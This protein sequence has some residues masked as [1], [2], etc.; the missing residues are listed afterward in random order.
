MSNSIKYDLERAIVAAITVISCGMTAASGSDWP[1]FRGNMQRTGFCTRS[2]VAPP[3]SKWLWQTALPGPIYSSPAVHDSLLFIGARDSNVYAL[4]AN[5]GAVVWRFKTGGQVESSPLFSNNTIY[6]GSDDGY[7]YGLDASGGRKLAQ[8]IA[9]F[10]LS[11]CAVVNSG[12]IV[13]GLGLPQSGLGFYRTSALPLH[14]VAQPE[15]LISLPMITYS[16]PAI[17]GSLVV[18][19]STDGGISCFDING[20]RLKWNAKTN[21]NMYLSSPAIAGQTVF[22]SP[23]DFDPYVY[24]LDLNS[25][26][27]LWASAGS[28]ADVVAKRRAA[29]AVDAKLVR[30]FLHSSPERRTQM[31]RQLG[32]HGID[33]SV[34]EH[35]SALYA[36]GLSKRQATSPTDFVPDG[37]DVKTSSVAVDAAN[38]Y[39]INRE[40]GYPLPRF[41]MNALD[42]SSGKAAWKSKFTELRNCL[43]I[44]YCSSPVVAGN[45]VFFGWG[46]GKVYALSADSGAVQ[47]QDSLSGDIVASPAITDDKLY[48]ATVNGFVYAFNLTAAAPSGDFRTRTYCYP[49]PAHG[50]VS[51]IQMSASRA[52]VIDLTVYSSAEKSVLRFSKQL[53]T[54]ETFTYDWDISHAANGVY[55]ALVQVK[56]SDGTRDSKVLKV[57]VLH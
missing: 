4:N 40:P 56:Y 27:T 2:N 19:G 31:I 42:R 26:R 6:I 8:F 9:G 33:V 11:S 23:G 46:E 57:A 49:N 24:A 22:C 25:G 51:H 52:G 43:P 37:L 14:G 10:Q 3:S 30:R 54:G 45:S 15:M 32:S 48:F 38:V 1:A 21:G 5:T 55:F 41:S 35:L 7:I 28:Q 18:V 39:V 53:T 13:S 34:L 29:D 36:G 50:S 16:S 20:Y 12:L 17:S 47:W 44:G